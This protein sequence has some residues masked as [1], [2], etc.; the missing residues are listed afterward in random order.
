MRV[1]LVRQHLLSG[2]LYM[3]V[4]LFHLTV[5]PRV[6]L[7]GSVPGLLGQVQDM[8]ILEHLA[9]VPPAH[10]DQPVVGGAVGRDGVQ[11]AAVVKA[12][13]G[14]WASHGGLLPLAGRP[15]LV[16]LQQP[17]LPRCQATPSIP[18]S[19]PQQYQEQMVAAM[20]C[21]CPVAALLL[22]Y[23]AAVRSGQLLQ[24]PC[25]SKAFCIRMNSSPAK[26]QGGVWL[27]QHMH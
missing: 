25:P 7:G 5:K 2:L 4:F 22:E 23:Y 14:G 18:A 20:S 10:D 16:Q 26:H 3:R 27:L 9:A 1:F 19:N 11:E 8:D 21:C 6:G 12:G 13:A 15:R 24:Q 17:Q